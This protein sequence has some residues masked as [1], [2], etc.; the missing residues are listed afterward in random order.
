MNYINYISSFFILLSVGYIYEKFNIKNLNNDDLSDY[1]LVRK[2]LIS[3]IKNKNLPFIWIHLD[4]IKNSRTWNSFGSRT[5]NEMNLPYL[6]I[7]I[8]TIINNCKDDFNI[9]L[10]DDNSFETLLPKLHIDLNRIADPIKSKYRELMIAKV[11]HKYGGIYLPPSFVCI[12]NLK[13]L[14]DTQQYSKKMF[15]GE[16]LNDMVNP[17][18]LCYY[19]SSKIMIAN[20][21][22]D[23]LL[24]LI[25]YLEHL[26]SKDNTLESVFLKA[27]NYYLNTQIKNKKIELISAEYIGV[28]DKNKNKITLDKLFDTENIELNDN[29]VG[30]YLNSEKL[31]TRKK[32]NWFCYLNRNEILSVNNYI[33]NKIKDI[34]FE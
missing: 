30:I 26:I 29:C 2:Y 28:R 31:L 8:Q 10:L 9:C 33:V 14:Y 18:S 22:C 5:D 13:T 20:K 34:L 27:I 19:P 12:K 3:D 25:Y 17:E 16:F 4:T 7:T 6:D 21:D 23:E 24:E 32:Y 15:V 1:D 11:L